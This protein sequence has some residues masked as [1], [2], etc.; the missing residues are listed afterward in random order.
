MLHCHYQ[1][2][3]GLVLSVIDGIGLVLS[4]I[5][6]ITRLVIDGITR[7]VIDG[8]MLHCHYQYLIEGIQA[9]TVKSTT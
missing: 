6:G 1:Y 7:L 2:L 9:S 3:I 4:V 8:I 5:D